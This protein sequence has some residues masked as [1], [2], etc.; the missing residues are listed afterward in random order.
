MTNEMNQTWVLRKRPVGDLK[1]GDLELVESALTPLQDGEVR[2]KTIYLSLDPT[3]R[4]WMSD[5]DAYLPPV[6]IG[7]PMRGGGLSIITESRFD[8]LAPGDIVN[9]G[10]PD[11]RST[12]RCRALRL[13]SCRACRV[14]R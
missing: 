14:C 1:E 12:T 8:G 6:Q 13:P 11:G 5:M 2:A 7:D 9:T 10:L 3:N 4:I